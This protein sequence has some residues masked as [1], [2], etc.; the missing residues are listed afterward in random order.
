M[1]KI[2]PDGM[3][4]SGPTLCWEVRKGGLWADLCIGWLQAEVNILASA[5]A[6]SQ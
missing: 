2:K 6:L 5:K 1:T 3:V 4:E